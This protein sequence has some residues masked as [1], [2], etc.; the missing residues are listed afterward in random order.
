MV[1]TVVFSIAL[2]VLA[3]QPLGAQDKPAE[4]NNKTA[5]PSASDVS[6]LSVAAA[7]EKATTSAIEKAEKSIVSIARIRKDQAPGA[8]AQQIEIPG[9]Q[10]FGDSP[11]NP[12]FVPNEFASGVIIS[13]DGMIVTCAHAIDDPRKYD[14]YV[15]LD[16]RVFPARVQARS[17]QVL[18]AD[19]YTDLA[20][21]KIDATDLTPIEFGDA[22]NVR[23]GSFVICLGNPYAVARDGQASASWGIVANLRRQAPGDSRDTNVLN[24]ESQHQFGTLIQTDARLNLGT[25]GGA[26]VNLRGEMIGLTTS[27]AA[28]SGFEQS[29]GY[30]IAVDE[31]FKRVVETLKT[32]H[33]PEFGFLGIQP[34]ELRAADR[35][36]G[37]RGARV[38]LVIPGLP[39][40]QAGL[41]IDDC[42]SRINDRPVED[43]NGLFRE[44]S[45]LPAGA[46][47]DLLVQRPKR[48]D[49]PFTPMHIKAT[50]SK[51]YIAT[52]RPSYSLHAPEPWRG[53][54]VEY[55]TAIPSE[56]V[57]GGPA[58]GRRVGAKLAILSVDPDSPA[59]VAGLRAGQAILTVNGA[60]VSTP[61][62]FYEAARQNNTDVQLQVFR[63]S[64]RPDTVVVSGPKPE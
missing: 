55:A 20:V 27:L 9:Q 43:R 24:K 15:W 56:L 53:M 35:A 13:N 51:K 6:Y 32:G 48:G 33:R 11:E 10:P 40:D 46:E 18:A 30:A 17:A 12:D 2:C 14:Y 36:A 31:M 3:T 21:L 16:K 25:S 45:Q 62:E 28:L 26:L 54:L 52:S 29:A 19:P 38:S 22:A 39:G 23:K 57:R 7:L 60:R 34:E 8:R 47:V 5:E 61:D 58:S 44:L 64:D 59:W 49:V 1:E 4:A 63:S 42:I 37:F 41:R 50:L